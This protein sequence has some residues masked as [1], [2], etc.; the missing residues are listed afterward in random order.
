MDIPL[1]PGE[2]RSKLTAL[3]TKRADSESPSHEATDDGWDLSEFLPSADSA[4]GSVV[5][6]RVCRGLVCH[7]ELLDVSGKTNVVCWTRQ[8]PRL[9]SR[10]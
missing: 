8:T 4:E 7:L 9:T 6:E 3:L 2:N 10:L 1:V 5:S